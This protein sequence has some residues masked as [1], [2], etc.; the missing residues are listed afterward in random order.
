LSQG[1]HN[2]TPAVN[3]AQTYSPSLQN[4][5]IEPGL[6]Q[7]KVEPT[8][9]YAGGYFAGDEDNS[10]DNYD[11]YYDQAGGMYADPGGGGSFSNSGQFAD[12][13]MQ[14]MEYSK[15]RAHKVLLAELYGSLLRLADYLIVM[16][17]QHG[18]CRWK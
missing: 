7:V 17:V 14:V 4:V 18:G 6:E 10:Y 13:A 15:P 16:I 11:M 9:E 8:A 3:Y 5:K 2:R 1:Q 12:D